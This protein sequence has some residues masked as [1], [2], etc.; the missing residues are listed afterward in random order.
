[1]HTSTPPLPS[2][3]EWQPCTPASAQHAHA[4]FMHNRACLYHWTQIPISIALYA[5]EALEVRL[6]IL[7]SYIPNSEMRTG[8]FPSHFIHIIKPIFLP[9]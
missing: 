9:V 2:V 3:A 6:L 8:G 4:D 1:M 7:Y 5:K